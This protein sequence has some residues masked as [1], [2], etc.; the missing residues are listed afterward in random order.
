MQE[1]SRP[2]ANPRITETAETL[3]VTR[4]I[5]RMR[6][7]SIFPKVSSPEKLDDIRRLAAEMV[8]RSLEE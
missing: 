2:G 5:G 4:R 3:V 1:E 6:I 7:S 8:M